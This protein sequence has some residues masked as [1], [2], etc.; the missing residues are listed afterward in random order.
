MQRGGLAQERSYSVDKKKIFI[1]KKEQNTLHIKACFKVFG[2]KTDHFLQ[3]QE[4]KPSVRL[5]N[6]TPK[7]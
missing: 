7:L 6:F 1:E 2:H 4:R 3:S 5:T